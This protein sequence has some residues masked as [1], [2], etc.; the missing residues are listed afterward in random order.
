MAK[1]KPL[2]AT[3]VTFLVGVVIG[4]SL[5]H[6]AVAP[7][8]SGG[9]P[10]VLPA[11]TSTSSVLLD[12]GDRR[13]VTYAGLSV[14]AGQTVWALMQELELTRG[15]R[16]ESKDFGGELGVLVTGIGGTVNDQPTARSWHYWVNQRF[17]SVG[18]SQYRLHPGDQVMWKY[19][20]NQFKAET[21]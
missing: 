8:G 14:A 4:W 10:L 2:L 21:K 13:V 5:P 16:L 20:T 12:F 1:L 3:F 17:A 9:A 18:A 7:S 15:L 19:T 6:S 11:P